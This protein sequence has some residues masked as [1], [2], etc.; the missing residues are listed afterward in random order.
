MRS[1]WVSRV[2]GSCVI[3]VSSGAAAQP[4]ATEPSQ[5]PAPDQ[6]TTVDLGT[7][8][9]ANAGRS[10]LTPTALTP[11]AGTFSF[12]D[13]ELLL[14]GISYAVSD[15]LVISAETMVPVTSDFY[16]GFASAK[17][18]ILKQGR[19]R[20][21]LQG[22]AAGVFAKS[23]DTV[24]DG[25]GNVTT[26][27]SSD[28]TGGLE[29]GGAATYCLDAPCFSHVDAFVG[30]AFAYQN[31]ASVPVGF[32]GSLVARLGRRVRL[33]LEAD[34]A[35]LFGDISGQADGILGWYGLRFTSREI[36]VDVGFVKPFC[37]GCSSDVLP[38]GFPVLSFTYR[39]M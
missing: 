6:A 10:W 28:S 18:Q 33:V 9:D 17:L 13:Y 36:G 26:T 25:M 32:A 8:E 29:V 39:G 4:A 16:W 15:Q 37:D 31:N 35:H 12:S 7:L 20:V 14:V 38:L 22:G 23:T 11:P 34:S 27:T 19:L 1:T 24:D 2:V 3:A 30:A 21:A 5:P